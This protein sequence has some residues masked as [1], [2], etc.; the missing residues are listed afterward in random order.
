V[1]YSRTDLRQAKEGVSHK[2]G[3]KVSRQSPLAIQSVLRESKKSANCREEGTREAYLGA[4]A[5]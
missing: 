4:G 3:V 1:P 2:G 5:N